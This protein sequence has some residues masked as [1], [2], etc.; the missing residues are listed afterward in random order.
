MFGWYADTV[1][2]HYIPLAVSSTSL[3]PSIFRVSLFDLVSIELQIFRY[4]TKI[5]TWFYH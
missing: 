5:M 4:V 1:C 2:Y 3:Q